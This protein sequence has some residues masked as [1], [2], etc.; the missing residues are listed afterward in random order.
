MLALD[1]SV[2]IA[3]DKKSIA[4]ITALKEASISPFELQML[5]DENMALKQKLHQ[6]HTIFN[7][8]FVKFVFIEGWKKLYEHWRS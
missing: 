8:I 6:I 7:I 2:A 4:E 5:R 1:A 3:E